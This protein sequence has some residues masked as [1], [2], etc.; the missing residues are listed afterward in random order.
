MLR[1][2]WRWET[3][4]RW[5]LSFIVLCWPHIKPVD[6]EYEEEDEDKDED[7]F[8]KK[9]VTAMGH[10]QWCHS[11]R[12]PRIVRRSSTNAA[13]TFHPLWKKLG[14]TRKQSLTCSSALMTLYSDSACLHLICIVHLNDCVHICETHFLFFW[15]LFHL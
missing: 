5:S 4:W 10:R 8:D 11:T 14:S 15:F 7:N 2:R 13:I 6:D 9:T 12:I 1:R 3:W